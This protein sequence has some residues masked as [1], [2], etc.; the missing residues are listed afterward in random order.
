MKSMIVKKC[1]SLTL[2]NNNMISF[3]IIIGC[4]NK[5]ITIFDYS[6]CT[7]LNIF[8]LFTIEQMNNIRQLFGRKNY[9]V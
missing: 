7:R 9:T 8:P 2:I 1:I 4:N 5:P 3:C 6:V